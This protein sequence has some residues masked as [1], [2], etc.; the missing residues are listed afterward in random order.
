M[1]EY[2]HNKLRTLS[3]RDRL[4]QGIKDIDNKLNLEAFRK[5]Q[6]HYRR[7]RNLGESIFDYFL[8]SDK[9]VKCGMKILQTKR[10]ANE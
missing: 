3:L 2:T 9:D 10:T 5:G 4:S 6:Y 1:S 7:K 8:N